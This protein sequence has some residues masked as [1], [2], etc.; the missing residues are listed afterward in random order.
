ML[1]LN[2]RQ[3]ANAPLRAGYLLMA[4]QTTEA[5][6]LCE[7]ALAEAPVDWP[8]R[9]KAPVCLMVTSASMPVFTQPFV[10]PSRRRVDQTDV[11]ARQTGDQGTT[12]AGTGGAASA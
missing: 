1:H 4:G 10:L 12:D 2:A 11:I 5:R 9:I 6:A 7:Q 3:L 8:G